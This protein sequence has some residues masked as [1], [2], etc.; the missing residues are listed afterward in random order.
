MLDDRVHCI[1][2]TKAVAPVMVGHSSVVFLDCQREPYESFSVKPMQP[3]QI[4]E[5]EYRVADFV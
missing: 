4:D 3:K 1:A 5:H 2:D